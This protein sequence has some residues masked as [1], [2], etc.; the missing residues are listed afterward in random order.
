MAA[1]R[2]FLG[3]DRRLARE[4]GSPDGARPRARIGVEPTADAGRDHEID[5]LAAVEVGLR[6]SGLWRQREQGG[7]RRR[8]ES[9]PGLVERSGTRPRDPAQ[10]KCAAQYRDGLRR[11]FL[12][13]VPAGARA[14]S[15][16]GPGYEL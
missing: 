4:C 7:R 8:P 3:H 10:N 15:L 6:R 9:C 12:S 13:W 16:A 2:M 5:G 11:R 1:A 14:A